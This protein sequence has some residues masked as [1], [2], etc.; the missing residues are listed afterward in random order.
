VKVALLIFDEFGFR[1]L[2]VFEHISIEPFGDY[3]KIAEVQELVF[4]SVYQTSSPSDNMLSQG[5]PLLTNFP[6]AFQ[7]LV[8][9]VLQNQLP[10]FWRH[11]GAH[12][13]HQTFSLY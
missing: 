2:R 3:I 1:E 6:A 10:Q 11:F 12:L 5:V 4:A 13:T 8:A 7:F 9:Q